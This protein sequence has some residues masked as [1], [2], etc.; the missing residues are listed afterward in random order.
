MIIHKHKLLY[1]GITKTATDSIQEFLKLRYGSKNC[2]GKHHAINNMTF[3]LE[4]HRVT[5]QMM[6]D[7][8]IFT[9]V[10]NPYA[11]MASQYRYIKQY[12]PHDPYFEPMMDY[13]E[14]LRSLKA[15]VVSKFHPHRYATMCEWLRHPRTGDI[16]VDWVGSVENMQEEFRVLCDELDERILGVTTDK[17]PNLIKINTTQNKKSLMD[18]YV[19]QEMLDFFNE[20]YQ[21][22][23]DEFGYKVCHKLAD[24]DGYDQT[25]G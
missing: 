2:L 21:E 4:K 19:D 20:R 24:F 6:D 10:R 1:I 3:P 13:T 16:T 15:G 25:R 14:F 8:F 12:R 18:W 22:D 17:Y 23:F 11:R 9:F 5:E 7:Y